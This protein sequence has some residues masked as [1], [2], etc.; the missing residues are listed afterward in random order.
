M[1]GELTRHLHHPVQYQ[2]FFLTTPENQLI[3]RLFVSP[4]TKKHPRASLYIN[5]EVANNGDFKYGLLIMGI[6]P[7]ET[8]TFGRKV[9]V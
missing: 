3:S 5:I 4:P 2:S 7:T 8:K 9:L 6:Y 1:D